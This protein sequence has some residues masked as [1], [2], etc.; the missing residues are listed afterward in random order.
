MYYPCSILQRDD[1]DGEVKVVS[2]HCAKDNTKP[3]LWA[4][5]VNKTEG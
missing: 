1:L 2:L 4:F 3:I 5:Y